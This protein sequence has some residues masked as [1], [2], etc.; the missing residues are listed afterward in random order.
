[1]FQYSQGNYGQ[2]NAVS[3]SLGRHVYE[4]SMPQFAVATQLYTQEEV[5]SPAF[6][7]SLRC[8]FAKQHHHSLLK[9]D[10]ARFWSTT[11][12]VPFL[13]NLVASDITDPVSRFIDKILTTTLV[14]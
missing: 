9:G 7:S 3:F 12:T 10:L 14:S 4:M 1:M 6:V 13:A 2:Y 8:V 5:Q 11:S